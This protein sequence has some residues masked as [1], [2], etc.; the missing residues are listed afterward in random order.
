M[1]PPND[2]VAYLS[3]PSVHQNTLVFIADDDLW[4]VSLQGGL[5]ARLTSNRGLVRNPKI[6]PDGKWIAYVS[7][8][9]GGFDAY[10][11]PTHGGEP[12]RLTYFGVQKIL[13]WKDNE[14]L[15]VSSAFETLKVKDLSLYSIDLKTDA[16]EPLQWGAASEIDFGPSGAVVIGRNNGDPARWKRYRG[17]TAGVLWTRADSRSKFQRILKNIT[18]NISTP[19]LIQGMIYFITDHE[20]YGNIYASDLSGKKLKRLTDHHHFY[21]RNLETDGTNLVYQAGGDLYSYNLPSKENKKIE[22][23]CP[24]SG[25]QALPRFVAAAKYI[26][27]FSYSPDL[28]SIALVARGHAFTMPPFKGAATNLEKTGDIRFAHPN[29]SFD[30][31]YILYTGTSLQQDEH[32]ILHDQKSGLTKTILAKKTWGKIQSLYTNPKKHLAVLQTNSSTYWMIDYKNQTSTLIEKS[33]AQLGGHAWSPCGRYLAY[34]VSLDQR[35]YFIKIFDTQNNQSR[36]LME[37]VLMDVDLSFDPEGKY[38]YILSV[39][40][41]GAIYNETH[42]DLGFPMALR[43]YIVVLAKTTPSPL[44]IPLEGFK[45]KPNEELKKSKKSEPLITKIDFDDIEHRVLPLPVDYGGYEKICGILGGL[46]YKRKKIAP[47]QGD[48]MQEPLGED[49][50]IFKFEKGKEEV[51]LKTVKSFY[52]HPSGSHLLAQTA[53]RLRFLSLTEAPSAGTGVGKTDGFIDTDRLRLHVNPKLEWKQMYREAWYLQKENFWRADMSKVN[54]TEVY[55][56][57]QPLLNRIKTRSEF[58]DLLWEM[59]GELGTSHAYEWGGDYHRTP[60]QAPTGFLGADFQYIANKKAFQIKQV[61][62]GDSYIAQTDSPLLKPA[63]AM[64][65]GDLIF[66]IN[67]HAFE[68]PADLWKSLEHKAGINIELLIQRKNQKN[69]EKVCVVPLRSQTALLY[70]Q[71][72]NKN[73]AYVHAASNGRL[74]YVHIPDMGALG[75]SEFYRNFSSEQIREGLV[76]DVR[77]NGG[78]HVSQ[79]ILKVLAQ[80][81]LGAGFGRH[82]GRELYPT[83]SIRGPLVAITNELAGS[84]GDIFSHSFKLM[85]LGP[86]VGK[87][88]WGG[89]I[90]IWPRNYLRDRSLTTQPEFSYYFKDV[91]WQVENYGTDPDYE[92][93]ITPEDYAA[94]RDPQMDKAIS[95][96]LAQ[97]KKTPSFDIT[98]KDYPDLRA[99]E[100]IKGQALQQRKKSR[101]QG[102]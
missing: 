11:I 31:K 56:K 28:Q 34:S 41:F 101:G 59:Q 102:V 23:A 67:S 66:A 25:I 1:T 6:S 73:K 97:I 69:K 82:F 75:F 100:L 49:L 57:Y 39:R 9:A 44:E 61:F 70:R 58:S 33:E 99:S 93:E 8:D 14:T 26:D 4:T 12:R 22:I 20:G 91:G 94:K 21:A 19:H 16:F 76:I 72:V 90:G 36:I 86:L 80:K 24:A 2:Q 95:L 84:D 40:E 74:G 96:A 89:V 64:S 62:R 30:S 15:I 77:F 32:L 47:F 88:T 42:F 7:Q 29:F 46:I 53:E 92:V 3:Q 50:F 13:R 65:E 45:L 27:S 17:G 51:L 43:P 37:P 81:P 78:G 63:V 71:W 52:V 60:P 10:I 98:I 85:K 48:W 55:N 38:L 18:T 68:G 79:H 83:Y 35:K 87:R 54:W 5:A